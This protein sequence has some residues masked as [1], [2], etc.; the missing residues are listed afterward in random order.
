L[1]VSYDF[2]K[3]DSQINGT[4]AVFY[5]EL[6]HVLYDR[7]P[8]SSDLKPRAAPGEP[9]L[10]VFS[11]HGTPTRCFSYNDKPSLVQGPSRT[12]TTRTLPLS[13]RVFNIAA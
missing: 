11:P 3:A 5:T 8:E 13:L 7:R 12:R 1:D 2:D 4:T 10:V 9:S 6:V